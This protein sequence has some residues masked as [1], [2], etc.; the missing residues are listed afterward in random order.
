MMEKNSEDV[1][2][3]ISL[4]LVNPE[5]LTAFL[6]EDY[7]TQKREIVCFVCRTS[8][9]YSSDCCSWRGRRKCC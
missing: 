5:K 9:E 4:I 3:N 7:F 8:L 1:L 2:E 6:P